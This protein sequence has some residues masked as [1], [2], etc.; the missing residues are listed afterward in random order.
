MYF[1]LTFRIVGHGFNAVWRTAVI[2]TRKRRIERRIVCWHFRWVTSFAILALSFSFS[3]TK[4]T[5]AHTSCHSN[6]VPILHHFWDITR[7]WWKSADVNLSHLYLAPPLGVMSLEFPQNFWHRKTTAP[8]LSYT[9]LSVILGLA[10]FVQLRLV[11]D[12]WTDGQTDTWW[13]LILR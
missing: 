7:Y 11:T 1:Q 3:L 2:S 13:Q 8:G 9:V 12:R 10:I 6:C 5:L 4:I